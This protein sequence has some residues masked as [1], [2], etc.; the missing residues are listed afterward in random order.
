MFRLDPLPTYMISLFYFVFVDVASIPYSNS[1]QMKR[2][3]IALAVVVR[4]MLP[5]FNGVARGYE[6]I[7]SSNILRVFRN[8]RASRQILTNLIAE[9]TISL[10]LST[11][12]GKLK[13]IR[14]F[15]TKKGAL[16]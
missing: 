15:L 12:Q 8:V 11:V 2:M 9:N 4:L 16:L 7:R 10:S 3:Q 1:L 6:G 5:L 13:F 14:F